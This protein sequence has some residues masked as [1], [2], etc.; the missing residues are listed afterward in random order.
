M[1]NAKPSRPGD[2]GASPMQ[3]NI[4]T[5]EKPVRLP[6]GRVVL[7]REHNT[8]VVVDNNVFP[9]DYPDAQ[10]EAKPKAKKAGE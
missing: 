10:P 9:G 8:G 6:D 5:G 4:M 2:R 3:V 1:A 7:R